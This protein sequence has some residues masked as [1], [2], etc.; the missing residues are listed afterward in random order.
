[1][2]PEELATWVLCV[3]CAILASIVIVFLGHGLWLQRYKKW[4][5]PLLTQAREAL[6]LALED[7]T[8][9][10]QLL[11]T[12]RTLPVRLQVRLFAELAPTLS[13]AQKQWLADLAREM[14]L[15]TRAESR[16]RSRL[17]WRRLQGARLV[18]LLG[19]RNA[20][21]LPLLLDRHPYVRAQAA[22]WAVSRQDSAVIDILLALL[23]DP[24]G[25]CR[26][27][28]QDS[29]LRMGGTVIERLTSYL[30]AHSG[31]EVK[32]A[33]EVAICLADP[34]FLDPALT[35]SQD[36]LPQIRSLAATLLSTLG[37]QQAVNTL[38][39]LLD[40]PAPSVRAAAAQALGK[41]SHW[42]AAPMLVP[43]L[44]DQVWEVR[45]EAGLA[46][47]ALGAPG[48]LFLRRALNDTNQ[49]AADMARHILD[50]PHQV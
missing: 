42:P 13:G 14:C 4:S 31:S 2:L 40:D 34:R 44:R 27:A 19:G 11:E 32:A 37:G 43:L 30:S 12:F 7:P 39:T 35:L 46:L 15:T 3:E 28:V 17:W 36:H 33:L 47:R 24:D 16:C 49:F 38:T 8:R 23:G 1:M 10:R 41:L 29:L 22:E 21:M 5:H 9:G 45:R 50:L 18:T 26:F 25:L 6:T 48:F 20:V